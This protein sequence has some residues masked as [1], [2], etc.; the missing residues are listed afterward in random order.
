MSF[1]FQ[2]CQRLLTSCSLRR[3]CHGNTRCKLPLQQLLALFIMPDDAL[4]ALAMTGS[5][6]LIVPHVLNDISWAVYLG[7]S[8]NNY[9]VVGILS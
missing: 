2:H 5:T 4:G 3:L 9:N 8:I 7:T 1:P 6:A